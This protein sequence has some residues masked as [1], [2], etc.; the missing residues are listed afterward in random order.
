MSA[1]TMNLNRG[2]TMKL[3][4][5]RKRK[6]KLKLLLMCPTSTTSY[7][8]VTSITL[9]PIICLD[10]VFCRF[11]YSEF[12]NTSC[13]EH[14]Y[15]GIA[16]KSREQGIAAVLSIGDTT[17]NQRRS[18]EEIKWIYASFFGKG[19]CCLLC[20]GAHCCCYNPFPWKHWHSFAGV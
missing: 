10:C 5:E 12:Q 1:K 16:F 17:R 13:R 8:S 9:S 4:K 7:D 14:R 2:W 11:F 3:V 20:Q 19:V 6:G 18:C 15:H